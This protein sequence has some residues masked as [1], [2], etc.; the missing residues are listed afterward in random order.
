MSL[1]C[2]V[3]LTS[4]PGEKL[5]EREIGKKEDNGGQK[6]TYDGGEDRAGSLMSEPRVLTGA[7]MMLKHPQWCIK[8][9][10]PTLQLQ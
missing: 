10:I 9:K 1:C 6:D 7:E 4:G 5:R 8:V 2:V 3:Q